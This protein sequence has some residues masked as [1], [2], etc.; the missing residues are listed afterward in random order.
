MY[1]ELLDRLT[2]ADD[3][4]KPISDDEHIKRFGITRDEFLRIKATDPIKRYSSNWA[5]GE[6]FE[7]WLHNNEKFAV[8]DRKAHMGVHRWVA[9]YFVSPEFPGLIIVVI[10]NDICAVDILGDLKQWKKFRVLMRQTSPF[11]IKGSTIVRTT[12]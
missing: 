9:R 11:T 3:M 7:D 6:D 12:A 10:L 8:V 4:F 1:Q 5:I 2:E